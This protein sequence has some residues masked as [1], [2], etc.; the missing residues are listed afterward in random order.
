M[1]NGNLNTTGKQCTN[2]GIVPRGKV[3]NGLC[4]ACRQYL[5]KHGRMRTKY[6]K[7][8]I[9]DGSLAPRPLCFN[10]GL[11]RTSG[12]R[13][14]CSACRQYR[15]VNGVDRPSYLWRESCRICGRPRN[16]GFA[17]GRCR[18]CY[19]YRRKYGR[20]RKHRIAPL[21]PY[22]WCDCG[23]PATGIFKVGLGPSGRMS[24]RLAMCDEC[25]R[26]EQEVATIAF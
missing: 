18:I 4:P 21:Y 20:D 26:V 6:D 7:R 14:L 25:A 1:G 3:A 24:E 15:R 11:S 9:W 17:K 10:C 16:V 8:V 12:S 22:G 2:C 19:N 5:R 23:K 13:S